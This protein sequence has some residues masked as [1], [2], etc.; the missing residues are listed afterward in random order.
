MRTIANEFRGYS[1]GDI[2]LDLLQIIKIIVIMAYIL[3]QIQMEMNTK[4]VYGNV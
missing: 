2:L 1:E 3:L 4:L